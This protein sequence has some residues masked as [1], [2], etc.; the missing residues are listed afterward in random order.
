MSFSLLLEQTKKSNEPL[1]LAA[2]NH[3]NEIPGGTNLVP[4]HVEVRRLLHPEKGSL[5]QG[6]LMMWVDMFDR[7]EDKP[8]P[9]YDVTPRTPEPWE[10][11]CIIWNTAD[12]SFL[13]SFNLNMKYYWNCIK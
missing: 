11:R 5:E 1:A 13:K 3:W 2:L 12:V 6:R 4:E 8:P 9:P 7:D 10:L